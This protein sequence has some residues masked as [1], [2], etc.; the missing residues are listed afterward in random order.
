MPSITPSIILS[1]FAHR[2]LLNYAQSYVAPILVNSGD[3]ILTL[4]Q[5]D[6]RGSPI[7]RPF[8]KSP[9]TRTGLLQSC[10]AS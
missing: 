7:K 4:G 2:I 8:V 10:Y 6:K 1:L 3:T 5:K 9:E